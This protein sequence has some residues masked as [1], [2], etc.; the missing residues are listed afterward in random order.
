MWC[1]LPLSASPYNAPCKF[2]E[3]DKRC[4]KHVCF[5]MEALSFWQFLF[6]SCAVSSSKTTFIGYIRWGVHIVHVAS[7]S[8]ASHRLI[9]MTSQ[10]DSGFVIRFG[11][12]FQCVQMVKRTAKVR[13]I[14]LVV[15]WRKSLLVCHTDYYF[16]PEKLARNKWN[17]SKTFVWQ[18]I[19]C[20]WSSVIQAGATSK[21]INQ[22]TT[23]TSKDL[24][25]DNR[26][27]QPAT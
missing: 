7:A 24:D 12:A 21:K 15:L 27:G 16:N 14:V 22:P 25:N 5:F 23:K 10:N 26:N 1:C 17:S 19:F 9:S 11:D 2:K 20:R 3:N 6:F 18:C 13:Q 8:L 4:A